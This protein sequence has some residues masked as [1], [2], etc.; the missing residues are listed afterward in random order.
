MHWSRPVVQVFER[1]HPS[2]RRAWLALA[3][4]VVLAVA[5]VVVVRLHDANARLREDLVGNRAVLGIAQARAAENQ[6][7]QHAGVPARNGDLRS[8]IDRVL[9]ANGLRYTTLD[10]QD[11]NTTQRVVVEVAPFDVLV[12]ALDML[13]R[14]EGLRVTDATLAARTDAGTVRAELAFTR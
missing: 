3:R 8:A 12:R 6:T 10:A 1:A 4:L 9:T 5:A 14:E 11:G 7:L 2:Q 13:Q